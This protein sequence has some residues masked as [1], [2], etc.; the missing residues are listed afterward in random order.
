MTKN[1]YKLFQELT[2]ELEA[3]V[4]D[5]LKWY[6]ENVEEYREWYLLD[7]ERIEEEELWFE[8]FS[9]EGHYADADSLQQILPLEMLFYSYNMR[10]IYADK[11]H[12]EKAEKIKAD[13]LNETKLKV[14]KEERFRK[15]RYQ[16]YIELHKE[17]GKD[18]NVKEAK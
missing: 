7:F 4:E 14:D 8:G 2:K 9:N 5:V 3:S 15:E 11:Y 1:R 18:T 16:H 10:K 6:N 12:Q 13:R 17:F